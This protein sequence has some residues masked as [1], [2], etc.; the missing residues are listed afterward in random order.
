MGDLTIKLLAA[1]GFI[2][3]VWIIVQWVQKK[4]LKEKL[5]EAYEELT[6]FIDGDKN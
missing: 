1:W 6:D 2:S 3:L 4:R 5:Y